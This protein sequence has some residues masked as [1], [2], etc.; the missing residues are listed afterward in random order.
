[1]G[2]AHRDIKPANLLVKDGRLL[3]IDVAFVEA[4]PTPWRQAVDL[5]NMMLCLGLRC[6][7]EGVYRRAL[8]YFTVEEITEGFAAARGLALPSQLRRMLRAQG[9][10]LHAE[11]VRLLPAPPVPVTIQRW[12]L[13]RIGL[14]AGVLLLAALLVG[15]AGTL[16]NHDTATKTTLGRHD[17]G[18]AHL[19]PLWLQAQSVPSASMLPCV[20]LLPAGWSVADVAVNDGRSVLTLDNDRAGTGA[21]VARLTAGCAPA[22]ATQIVSDQQQVRRYQRTESLTPT[23][24][25]TRFDVFPGGCVTTRVRAPA[26]QA[27]E[28]VTEAPL[29]L[30]FTTRQALQQALSQRS[31]GRLQLD[32]GGPRRAPS[33]GHLHRR[34]GAD[35]RQRG[36]RPGSGRRAAVSGADLRA[37]DPPGR[38]HLPHLATH[39]TR[40]KPLHPD[41]ATA[42]AVPP[43]RPRV[44]QVDGE[45]NA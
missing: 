5:A 43:S 22:G 18:C 32:P 1:L 30:G 3:L 6:G 17:L 19:E 26:A 16:L 9:R 7:A 35:G 29:I 11:F 39:K 41:T 37:A 36:P 21:M 8:Q 34:A 38:V 23:F 14:V 33:R 28:V 12:S 13:R 44:F 45:V 27:P 24:Q 25:A 2:L 15:N 20:R 31:G 10:G 42:I 4:C 40:R